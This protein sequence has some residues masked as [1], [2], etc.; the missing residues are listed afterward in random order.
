ME[1]G[2]QYFR[3]HTLWKISS[4]FL[5][6]IYVQR[7]L[8]RNF[9]V[10]DLKSR[11]IGSFIG[12]FWSVIHPIVLL[13]TYTFVFK[14]IFNLRPRPDDIGTSSFALF[15]FC[16][17]L[18]WLLFQ[19]SIQRSSTIIIENAN[20]ATKTLFPTETLPLVVLLSGLVNHLIG[21]I[22]LLVILVFAVG[23]ISIFILLIPVYIFF[24][25]VF[26]LG[27][28]WFVA[29]LNVFIRD[30]SQILSVILTFWFWSTPIFYSINQFPAKLKFLAYCNPLTP[31]VT[32]YRDCLLQRH[33][34]NL[35]YLAT[36]AV[37]SLAIF[38]AGGAF[39][40]KTK[41]EFADIL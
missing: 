15:L 19:D 5:R 27:I 33:M 7:S 25:M 28:S 40:R 2:S 3:F 41:R 31:V 29:S 38:L 10:R 35:G 37:I 12:L 18:P 1:V 14:Y 22:I 30:T 24:L 4:N 16:G 26:T 6:K 11:Y 34:P 36:F 21:F 17:I 8:I 39:F 9:V 13:L 23:K 32:G 20:L